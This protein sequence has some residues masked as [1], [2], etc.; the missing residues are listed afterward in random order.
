V[1]IIVKRDISVSN[2]REYKNMF[3]SPCR[4]KSLSAGCFLTLSALGDLNFKISPA[5]SF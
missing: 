4:K 3:L 1:G 5:G 2:C